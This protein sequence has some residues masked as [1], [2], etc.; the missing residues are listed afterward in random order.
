MTQTLAAWQNLGKLAAISA[1]SAEAGLPAESTINDIG[2][3]S[4]A[5]QTELGVTTATI[6]YTLD[7]P[8]SSVRVVGLFRTNLTS[9]AQVTL[10][11]NFNSSDTYTETLSGPTVGYGQVVFILPDTE[12]AD[13]VEI[14]ISDPTNPDSVLNIPLVFIG[15]AWLPEWSV[16]P[17]TGDGWAG[18]ANVL[19]TRGGQIY[20]TL[21]ANPRVVS[22]EFAAMTPADTFAAAREIARLAALGTNVLFIIDAE[23]ANVAQDAVF[24]IVSNVR[25]FGFLPG[26]TGMRTWGATVTERL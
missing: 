5:W 9:Q 23:A 4:T 25:P 16:S 10:T 3:A 20:Q 22:F 21:L 2:D 1:T 8:G 13:T 12:Y 7:T 18:N 17:S 11:I 26:P 6:T 14:E 19:T 24:G 15:D